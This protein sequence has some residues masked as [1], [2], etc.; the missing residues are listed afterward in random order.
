MRPVRFVVLAVVTLAC[1]P[2]R[3]P[4]TTIPDTPDTRAVLKVVEE[5]GVA[6]QQKDAAAL[7]A[8]VAPTYFDDAGTTDPADDLDHAA[9]SAA[10]PGDLAR[11]KGLRVEIVV[12]SLEVAGDT[13][14]AEVFSDTWY[15]VTVKDGTVPRRDTDVHRMRFVRLQGGWKIASG[16]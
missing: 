1:T 13:A 5:Y 6:L 15:Q 11:L 2:P 16:L 4:N 3:I 12:R 9:L 7:L 14:V 10:L 8:L